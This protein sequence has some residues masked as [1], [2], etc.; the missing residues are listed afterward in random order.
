MTPDLVY[1]FDDQDI[2]EVKKM[3]GDK[4]VRRL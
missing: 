2:A 3:M 1:C 4:Q